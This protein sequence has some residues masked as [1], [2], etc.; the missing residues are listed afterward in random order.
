MIGATLLIGGF[1]PLT[2]VYQ[3]K[4]DKADGVRTISYALG[5][6]GTFIFTAI[7][8]LLAMTAIALY[9][10]ERNWP[11]N[12]FIL[13][14]FLLPVLTYFFWWMKKIWNDPAQAN[15]INTMRMN[16]IASGF[17]NAGFICLFLIKNH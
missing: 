3:H 13:Q 17:T 14:M 8:Y 6:R 1:Y 7:I 5:I 11:D 16:V 10:K 12:F 2:Q 4:E 9:M 15:Y